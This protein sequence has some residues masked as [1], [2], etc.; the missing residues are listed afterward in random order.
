MSD[1]DVG[2][3]DAGTGSDET[4]ATTDE[5]SGAPDATGS[6][7]LLAGV[8]VVAVLVL[9][10]AGTVFDQRLAD[11]AAELGIGFAWLLAATYVGFRLEGSPRLRVV[12]A[13]AFV[14]AAVAQFL[15]LFAASALLSTVRL[16]AVLVGAA[17]LLVV[18]AR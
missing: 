13:L 1:D 2:G 16:V 9:L 6:G 8:L 10:L 5:S 7:W 12:G 18:V 17:I 15:S 11:R 3:D 4:P 14:V